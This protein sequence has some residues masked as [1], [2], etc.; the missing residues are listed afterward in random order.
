MISV[1]EL[2]RAILEH[3]SRDTSYANCERLAWLYIVRD[4]LNGV[5]SRQPVPVDADGESDFLKAVHGRDSVHV[6]AVLD[7][8][9]ETLGVV[10]PRLYAA[11]LRKIEAVE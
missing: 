10:N 5:P 6:W 7:E 11:V 4:H 9:M 3:E 1:D 8:L 2:D